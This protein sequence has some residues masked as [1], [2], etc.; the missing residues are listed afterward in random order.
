MKPTESHNPRSPLSPQGLFRNPAIAGLGLTILIG[1]LAGCRSETAYWKFA[2]AELDLADQD[3]GEVIPRLKQAVELSGNDPLLMLSLARIMGAE[4]DRDSL[5]LFDQVLGSSLIQT[6]APLKDSVL[7]K[8]M[9]ALQQL[10][11]YPQALQLCK[12]FLNQ[13][14]IRDDRMLNLLAYCRA[15][16]GVELDQAHG[17]I[18]QA[19]QIR[20][21]GTNWR[22]ADRLHL[23]GKTVV[24][25]GLLARSF[26]HEAGKNP[27]IESIEQ[28]EDRMRT[29]LLMLTRLID[30]YETEM[31]DSKNLWRQIKQEI[32]ELD[33]DPLQLMEAEREFFGN[34]T[35]L[36]VCLTT[37]GLLYQDLGETEFSNRD[38]YRIQQLNK[39]ANEML[40]LLPDESEAF[41]LVLNFSIPYLDTQGF[42]LVQL[43]WGKETGLF[44][45]DNMRETEEPADSLTSTYE[46]TLDYLDLA[47][48]SAQIWRRALQGDLYNRV[49]FPVRAVKTMQAEARKTEA[50]LRYHRWLAHQRANQQAKM[51]EDERAIKALGY[52]L[53]DRL[54]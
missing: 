33:L 24:A 1:L 12:E 26:Y 28:A 47:V 36:I 54:F 14:T 15:L 21:L 35:S 37:R 34:K 10:G 8:K 53:D 30:E 11:D 27:R 44:N 2:R 42:I 48:F 5:E 45:L 23:R 6:W 38:R 52:S 22:C 49:D 39:D 32:A 13:T 40:S 16:A 9:L 3:A 43:P 46:Q 7:L 50:V 20:Q 25:N 29:A 51:Q 4:G 19:I 17:N 18:Q 31:A 41:E